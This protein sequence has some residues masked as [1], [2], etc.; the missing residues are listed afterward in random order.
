MTKFRLI[1][2]LLVATITTPTWSHEVRPGY[3]ELTEETAGQFAVLWKIPARGNAILNLDAVLPE[4]CQQMSPKFIEDLPGARIQRWQVDC[5]PEGLNGKKV[6]IAGLQTTLADVLVRVALLEGTT[7][8]YLLK[9]EYPST[10]IGDETSGSIPVSGYLTLGIEHILL[11][12]DHLLFVLALLLIVR[13]VWL[14]VKTVTSFTI[15]HSITLGLA[16]VGVLNVPI[17]PVE[18]AIA[19]SIVFV[20]AEIIRAQR[21]Q[22]SLTIRHPWIAAFGFGLLHGLGFASALAQVGLPANEIPWALLLF[23][24]GVELGQLLFI[25]AVLI[26]LASF[27]RLKIRWPQWSQPVPAYIIGSLAASWFIGRVV[28]F[29]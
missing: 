22:S 28:A 8:S 27:R 3:L 7:Y 20:G 17:A 24:I 13:G 21:G 15:A 5:N 18:A 2:L 26:A 9:P 19:L 11:G 29:F 10:I 4:S 1:L 14:L 12:I 23:N 16:T 6:T 25:A